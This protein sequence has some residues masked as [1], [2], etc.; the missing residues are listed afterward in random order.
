MR[1]CADYRELLSAL[2]DGQLGEE[3]RLKL[4]AHIA[5][6][7]DCAALYEAFSAVSGAM[8]L[9]EPPAD[10]HE[11]VMGAVRA[12]I[13]KKKLPWLMPTLSAAACF[14]AILGSVMILRPAF[15]GA[16]RASGASAKEDAAAET[17]MYSATTAGADEADAG[18]AAANGMLFGAFPES[19]EEGAPMEQAADFRGAESAGEPEPS[20]AAE[21][22]SSTRDGTDFALLETELE[23][24]EI[25]E[26]FFTGTVIS[27]LY[28]ILQEGS[29]LTV[30]TG[31]QEAERLQPG[32]RVT[33]RYYELGPIEG[34]PAPA[35]VPEEIELAE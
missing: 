21:L 13:P 27:G 24:T 17:V 22:P 15:G 26:D 14:V 23:V 7:A 32:D 1:D 25:G 2:L 34:Y 28:E 10:L 31:A 3:E 29:A 6:C 19:A 4:R 33:V 18:A 20:A 5:S 30:V 11:K 9:E 8:E 16:G 35:V 12:T